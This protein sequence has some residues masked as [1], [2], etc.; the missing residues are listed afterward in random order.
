VC[1]P[2]KHAWTDG[3]APPFRPGD[4]VIAVSARRSKSEGVIEVPAPLVS[5]LSGD[6][7]MWNWHVSPGHPFEFVPVSIY[8]LATVEE[9]RA[10]VKA[11]D[12]KI[13]GLMG[14]SQRMYETIKRQEFFSKGDT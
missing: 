3:S 6:K 1:Q 8:R 4:F 12:S 10:E 13:L 5:S 7:V 14:K 11:N 9:L 2:D